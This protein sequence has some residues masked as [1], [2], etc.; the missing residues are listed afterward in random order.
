MKRYLTEPLCTKTEAKTRISLPVWFPFFLV[1]ISLALY[2]TFEISFSIDFCV[3]C[4]FAKWNDTKQPPVAERC[5]CMQHWTFEQPALT[6]S[7]ADVN[8]CC[9][10]PL[11]I[12]VMKHCW[13]IQTERKKKKKVHEN[14]LIFFNYLMQCTRKERDLFAW[15]CQLLILSNKCRTTE[16]LFP[17]LELI[18]KVQ[19][20]IREAFFQI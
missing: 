8:P 17:R 5:P 12:A 14:H 7:P 18:M 19:M 15:S 11:P 6:P 13:I 2:K 1:R 9:C 10:L 16:I 3:V 4:A 20:F